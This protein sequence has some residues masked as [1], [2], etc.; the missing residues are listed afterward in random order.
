MEDI[1]AEVTVDQDSEKRP[2]Q[3][4]HPKSTGHATPP[5]HTHLTQ[6]GGRMVHDKSNVKNNSSG[7]KSAVPMLQKGT[8]QGTEELWSGGKGTFRNIK[9]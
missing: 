1:R 9:D 6:E 5:T 3:L 4:S 7:A 8:R 2:S